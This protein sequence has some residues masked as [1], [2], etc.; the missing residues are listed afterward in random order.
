MCP[1]EII[2]LACNGNQDA[3]KFC[4]AFVRWVHFVDDVIDGDKVLKVE[5]VAGANLDVILAFSENPFFSSYKLILMPL[6]IQ[7]SRA[8]VDSEDFVKRTDEQDRNA[9][10]VLKGFYHEV[11]WHVA[12]ICGG[13][14]HMRAVTAACRS[15]DYDTH[16]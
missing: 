13:W 5:E 16:G 12:Y 8:W 11:V 1:D 2:T 14:E 9:S 3:E 6:V 4:R 15:Y 10:H 7:A